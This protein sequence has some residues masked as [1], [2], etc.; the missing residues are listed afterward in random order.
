MKDAS[1]STSVP[2][3]VREP[4]APT[5][6]GTAPATPGQVRNYEELDGGVGREV[7]FRPERY[8]AS[9][10]GAVH[11][12]VTVV[13]DGARTWVCELFDVSQNGVAFRTQQATGIEPGAAIRRLTISFDGYEA[14]HGEARVISVRDVGGERVVGVS[15][16]DTLM[17]IEDV[18]HLRD[19]RNW[20]GDAAGRLALG[21]KPWHVPGHE[22]FK[23]LVGEF[24][25]FLADARQELSVVE[26]NLSSQVTHGSEDS[27]A[28]KAMIGVLHEQFVSVFLRYC[29]ELDA[30]LRMATTQEWQA[31]KEFSLRHLDAYLM[32]APVLNRARFKPLGY[33][34]D[35]EVMKY[36]YYKHFEGESLFARAIH[37]ASVMTPVSLAVRNR[38][39][40]IKQR[41]RESVLSWTGARPIRIVSVGCGPALDVYEM[42][43]ELEESPCDMEIVLFDQDKLALTHAFNSVNRLVSARWQNRVRVTYLHDSIRRLL[44]DPAIFGQGAT[45]DT[46]VCSG[47]YDY[48]Q[49]RTAVTLTRNM[50]QNLSA[51]GWLYVGNMTPVNTSRWIMEHHLDWNLIY[52]TPA[53]M[54]DLSRLA[55]PDAEIEILEEAT[56]INPFASLRRT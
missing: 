4:V 45:F 26:K 38:K 36:I 30:S 47:L 6:T 39:E 17:D 29:R 1:R 44:K 18:L 12:V 31:L 8:R 10:L 32:E 3:L 37:L 28:R 25:L 56:G 35:F 14:Y 7:F 9:D 2:E 53:E 24:S 21:N 50:Y 48:L 49:L 23:S 34:G 20:N 5:A 19:V 16:V 54:A 41:L 27:V 40:V 46:I 33:P 13:L 55:A 22:R 52:R 15:F 42:L 11:P 43:E 51:G